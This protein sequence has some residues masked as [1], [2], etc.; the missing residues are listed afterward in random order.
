MNKKISLGAALA[1]MLIVAAAS[2][3]ITMVNAKRMMTASV[4]NLRERE[5][6]YDKLAEIDAQVRQNY[7]GE[8]DEDLL[9]DQIAEGYISGIG[10]PYASYYTAQEYNELMNADSQTS[11]GIG[12]TA[13]MDAS[14]YI[15]VLDVYADSPA[16]SS[17]IKENNLITKVDDLEVNQDTYAQAMDSIKG[18]AGTRL[19]L[20]VRDEETNEEREVE[21]TRRVVVEPSVFTE[22]YDN[23]GYI[24]ISEFNDTTYDQFRRALREMERDSQIQGLIFDVRNNAGGT[25]NA[26]I[27]ILDLLLPAG[28]IM[29]ATYNNGETR[30]LAVSDD[31]C[32]TMPMAVLVNENT[33]S[34]AELFAQALKDYNVA[35]IVGV[36]TMGKGSM[37]Q[38]FQLSDGSAVHFTIAKYNPPK[39]GNFE[40][41][42]VRPD[43]EVALTEEQQQM[44]AMLD[45]TTEPQLQ[46]ALEYVNAEINQIS[47]QQSAQAETEENQGETEE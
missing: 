41:V 31:N 40:G 15:R 46:K 4:N 17:G 21:L 24:R 35:A 45:E 22:T 28:D 29:S 5:A 7:Y 10:D 38:Y 25:Q 20:V 11:A 14:G 23:V 3:S 37:Q 43:Y 16:E 36:R 30:V 34:A 42:G 18:A 8:I 47:S 12:I 39:S 1:F 9:K 27:R 6:M 44:Y 2:V 13:E 33:A 32:V 26:V 19:I